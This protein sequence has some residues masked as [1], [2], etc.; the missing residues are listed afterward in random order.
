MLALVAFTALAANDLFTVAWGTGIWLGLFSP[1]WSA[2]FFIG[3]LFLAGMLVVSAVALW[4]PQDLAQRAQPLVTF[5]QRIGLLRWPL[6][7][8][9]LII[10]AWAW[11]FA[12]RREHWTLLMG[13]CYLRN[14]F[15]LLV[16]LAVGILLTRSR[17]R[18]LDPLAGALGLSILGVWLYSAGLFTNAVNYP[19]ALG[20]SEGNR[21]YDYSLVFGQDLYNSP[22]RIVNPYNSPLRYALWGLAFLIKGLPIYAH[23]AWDAFL[24]VLPVS[25]AAW[26]LVR[27]VKPAMLRWT[28]VFWLVL[29]LNQGPI[30]PHLLVPALAMLIFLYHPN[31]Y[32]RGGSALAASLL[33]G[34]SRWTWAVGPGIWAGLVDLLIYYPQRKGSPLRRLAPALGIGLAG[35]LP[36]VLP[37][38]LTSAGVASTSLTFEQ[39]LL[40]YRLFPNP[41][42]PPGILQAT[43]IASGPVL[44]LL[45]WLVATRRWQM[46]RLQAAL[47]FG[48]LT[49]LLA[50]GTVISLKIG[51]GGDLHNLDLYLVSLAVLVGLYFS[52]AEHKPA[53]KAAYPLWMNAALALAMLVPYAAAVKTSNLLQLPREAHS[54]AALMV[55]NDLATA[56]PGE[57]LFMDQRQLL[58]FGFVPA[59]PFIPEYEKKYM[60]DQAMAGNR[61]YFLAYY[62]DLAGQRFSLIITEPLK[63][64]YQDPAFDDFAEETNAWVYWVVEPT[65]CFYEP[66]Y[67]FEDVHVQLLIPRDAPPGCSKYVP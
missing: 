29:F 51:G 62:R 4:R 33:M 64:A 5:R 28:L 55:I 54:Q 43:L 19:F 42:F 56:A 61:E 22:A 30:Y 9:M 40:V 27:P 35:T 7:L 58:T 59:V 66:L 13:T 17:T 23:R 24:Y 47:T 21:L 41:T 36:G 3:C 63:P 65:L 1:F 25:V 10:A 52:S 15:F 57:V 53:Q 34:L 26:C 18:L 2:A 11:H 8:A 12:D 60:M 16:A 44:L 45:I 46:D 67:T 6:I 50:A 32:L 31:P 14:L 49:A 37:T 39:P 38:L 20:W 48:G